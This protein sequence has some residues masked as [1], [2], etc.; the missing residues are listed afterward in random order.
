M[1]V[2]DNEVSK[3]LLTLPAI[4]LQSCMRLRLLPAVLR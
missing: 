1:K 2:C 4:V 3:T